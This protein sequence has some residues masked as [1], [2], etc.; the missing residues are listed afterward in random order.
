[1]YSQGTQYLGWEHLVP[2][3]KF[4]VSSKSR[5]LA[6]CV[7]LG[8]LTPNEY[9]EKFDFV[10]YKTRRL[11]YGDEIVLL[12]TG[13]DVAILYCVNR[14]FTY[15]DK[16]SNFVRRQF[17]PLTHTYVWIGGPSNYHTLW[18]QVNEI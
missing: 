4:I 10:Y 8:K 16:W 9:H 14:N 15:Q 2:G 11:A 3:G 6:E 13:Y 12:S 17:E 1:M 5:P 7:Y 18:N